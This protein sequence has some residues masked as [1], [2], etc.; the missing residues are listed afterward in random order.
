ME[1]AINEIEPDIDIK[2]N[3]AHLGRGNFG[4]PPGATNGPSASAD[5]RAE[6]PSW[7]IL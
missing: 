6:W 3:F 4:V 5:H 1:E 2:A 7:S